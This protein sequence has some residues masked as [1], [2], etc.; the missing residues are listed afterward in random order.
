M[1]WQRLVV[2]FMNSLQL[3][4][5]ATLNLIPLLDP[6]S[7]NIFLLLLVSCNSIDLMLERLYC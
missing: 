5:G 4:Q 7:F 1:F 3:H 2:L 6:F